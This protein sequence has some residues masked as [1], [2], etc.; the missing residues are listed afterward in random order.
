MNR[1]GPNTSPLPPTYT[2]KASFG[3]FLTVTAA[4]VRELG[5]MCV[6]IGGAEIAFPYQTASLTV[7]DRNLL[8]SGPVAGKSATPHKWRG[9]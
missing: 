1:P 9:G 5:R 6:R 3:G 8:G 4:S 2:K 7:I